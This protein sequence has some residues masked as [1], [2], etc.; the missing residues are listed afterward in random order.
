V[1]GTRRNNT[2]AEKAEK[3]EQDRRNDESLLN[4]RECHRYVPVNI[5]VDYRL[6]VT[7]YR[8]KHENV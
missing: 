1:I 5:L 2:A 6:Q 8:S 7:D 3:K 4:H